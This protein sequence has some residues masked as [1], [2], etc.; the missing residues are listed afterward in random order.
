MNNIWLI[1]EREYIERVKKKSFLLATLLTPLIFPLIGGIGILMAKLDSNDDKKVYV[2]DET[3][4]FS[5][6]FVVEDYQV[7]VSQL[8][9]EEAKNALN[10]KEIYGV[11]HIPVLDTKKPS[12]IAF[13]S[14]SSPGFNFLGKFKTPIKEKIESLK[15]EELNLDRAVIDQLKTSF[16]ISTFNVS[17]TGQSKKSNTAISSVMGYVMAFLIYM[18]VFVYGSFIMQS[19]LNEKTNKIVEIIVSSIKPF[20][21][22]LGKV[23]GVG[24]VALTQFVIWIVLLGGI[25]IFSATFFNYTP[26]GAEQETINQAIIEAQQEAPEFITNILDVVY[27]LPFTQIIGMFIIYFLGGFFLFGGLFA[28]VGSAVDSLQEAQQFTLPISLPIIASIVLMPMVL[29]N[30]DGASSIALTMI[31]FTSPVLMMARV[32]FGVPGWQILISVSLLI[33]GVF[34]TLWLAGKIYRIGILTTGSK[35]TYKVLAKWIMMKN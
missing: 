2:I 34:F 23:L 33:A 29:N 31:P 30:P 3:G 13:Y 5:E 11:L 24:A 21:L 10:E 9:L 12:G 26:A 6:G 19:V 4:W 32:P 8:S 18:F 16:D 1:I 7:E 27:A 15:M 22:M 14:R 35:V 17:D 28:A 25:T 20:H